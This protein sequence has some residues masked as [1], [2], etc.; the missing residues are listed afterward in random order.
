MKTGDFLKLKA[1]VCH[2]PLLKTAVCEE[3]LMFVGM[4][5]KTANVQ[6]ERVS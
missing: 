1:A 3:G 5:T 6:T 2:H 4:K